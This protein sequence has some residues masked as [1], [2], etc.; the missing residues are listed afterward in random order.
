MLEKYGISRGTP[1]GVPEKN[2]SM[3][4]S[5][6]IYQTTDTGACN[7]GE[8]FTTDGRIQSLDLVV[9]EDDLKYFPAYNAAPV[10]NSEFLAQY[11]KR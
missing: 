1:E 10:F 7:L 4:D 9:L 6:T 5:G 8:V 3:M 11:L 2:I